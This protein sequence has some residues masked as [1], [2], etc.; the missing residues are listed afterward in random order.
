MKRTGGERR[1]R[2]SGYDGELVKEILAFGHIL[3]HSDL[4]S[5]RV[6]TPF[7]QKRKRECV[8]RFVYAF[9]SVCTPAVVNEFERS[10][11]SQKD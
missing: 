7:V 3:V 1:E 2:E 8:L 9:T 4:T 5:V 6:L 10:N 11:A